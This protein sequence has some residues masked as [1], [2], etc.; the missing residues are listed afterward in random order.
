LNLHLDI[1]DLNVPAFG[2]N[3]FTARTLHRTLK[4]AYLEYRVVSC[5]WATA[6]KYSC[7]TVA[8]PKALAL[9]VFRRIDITMPIS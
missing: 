2:I 7:C 5:P 4:D 8:S 6:T 9:I 1:N 3:E